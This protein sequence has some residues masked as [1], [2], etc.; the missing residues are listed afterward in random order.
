MRLVFLLLASLAACSSQTPP[1]KVCE[2]LSQGCA[3]PLGNSTLQVR[4][5]IQPKPLQPFKLQ[6]TLP[7]AKSVDVVLS[8]RG[9]N[10]G[11]NHYRLQADSQGI[12]WGTLT[13]PVCVSGRRDWLL[14]IN[15]DDQ[16]TALTFT[17]QE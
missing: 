1:A 16:T 13:L 3:L 4:S 10:M 11:A 15:S 5:N 17:T 8:M 9:M 7:N 2:H 14:T 6:V 12:W